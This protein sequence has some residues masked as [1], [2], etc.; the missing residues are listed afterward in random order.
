MLNCWDQ[1]FEF[2]FVFD[3][4]ELLKR[5]IKSISI[6]RRLEDS[7]SEKRLGEVVRVNAQIIHVKLDALNSTSNIAGIKSIK[8]RLPLNSFH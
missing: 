1:R 7:E 5:S 8:C 4:V 3:L 2:K 6:L